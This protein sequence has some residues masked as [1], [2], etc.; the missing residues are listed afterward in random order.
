LS[1]SSL[2]DP[3]FKSQNLADQTQKNKIYDLLSE[4]YE[5]YKRMQ[6]ED[7]SEET[8]LSLELKKVQISQEMLSNIFGI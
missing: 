6:P 3:R 4:K 5:E 1:L 2:L 8:R 7:L